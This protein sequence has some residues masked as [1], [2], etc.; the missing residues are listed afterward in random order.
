[1]KYNNASSGQ[2]IRNYCLL[3]LH[4]S[5]VEYNAGGTY[6]YTKRYELQTYAMNQIQL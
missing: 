6:T 2:K 5:H 4:S 3:I 1:M